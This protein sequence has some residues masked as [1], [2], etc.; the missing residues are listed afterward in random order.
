[1][2]HKRW[3]TMVVHTHN[4]VPDGPITEVTTYGMAPADA[5]LDDA[6]LDDVF[7]DG[8]R[9]MAPP[10]QQEEGYEWWFQKLAVT[11]LLAED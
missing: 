11:S 1:M 4:Y 5:W 2:E 6:T 9:L 10:T 3:L 8:W 7:R